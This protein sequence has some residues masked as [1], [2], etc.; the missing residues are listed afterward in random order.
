MD[1]WAGAGVP[2]D[3]ALVASSLREGDWVE[4]SLYGLSAGLGAVGFVADPVAALTSAGVGWAIEHVGPLREMLDDL[5][6]DPTAVM[7]DAGRLEDAAAATMTSVGVVRETTSRHLGDMEGE[8]VTAAA[9]F[10]R[11][12]GAD[13][14]VFAALVAAGA[15]AMRRA[16][17]LVTVVRG[18]V[19]DAISELVGMATSSAVTVVVTAGA[20]VPGVVLRVAARART[21]TARLSSTLAA[22]ARSVEGLRLLLDRAEGVLASLVRAAGD[23]T[24]SQIPAGATPVQAWADGLVRR[25][26]A[27]RPTLEAL[28]TVPGG[29]AVVVHGPPDG[30]ELSCR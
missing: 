16:S 8:A 17:G 19:R 18:L 11:G 15:E 13:C 12:A 4:A 27:V 6:G 30:E 5:A 22:L 10:A 14:E 1:A 24:P 29:L 25:V 2:H 3:A 9:E 23:R 20:A 21:L 26:H 7:A 28:H